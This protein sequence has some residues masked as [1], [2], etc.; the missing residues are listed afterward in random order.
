MCPAGV[1]VLFFFLKDVAVLVLLEAKQDI[2]LIIC[3]LL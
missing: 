2:D 3:F 1:A